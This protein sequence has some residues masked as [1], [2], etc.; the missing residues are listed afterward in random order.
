MRCFCFHASLAFFNL[1]QFFSLPS[2][3]M[4]L[5]FLKST[6]YLFFFFLCILSLDLGTFHYMGNRV[7]TL[8]K[9]TTGSNPEY[10]KFPKQKIWFHQQI[11]DNRKERVIIMDFKNLGN[12][13]N[14]ICRTGLDSNFNKPTLK[15]MCVAVREI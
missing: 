11:N 10:G 12:S 9:N 7:K 14:A 15:Y 5:A 3:F 4:I 8:L 13:P 2:S 1:S 6:A